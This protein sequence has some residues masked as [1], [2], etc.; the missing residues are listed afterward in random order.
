MLFIPLLTLAAT[1]G[2]AA[3]RRTPAPI[4]DTVTIAGD[5]TPL[6]LELRGRADRTPILLYLHG[7]PGNAAGLVLLRAY[8]GP[9]LEKEALVVYLHQ[10]GVLNSPAVPDTGLTVAHHVGD[11]RKTINYLTKR[12]P[13][14]PIVLLGHSWGGLLAVLTA[15]D[16]PKHIAGIVNASGPFDM[17]ATMRASYER[18]LAWARR[19]GNKEAIATLDSIG[20][21]PYQQIDQ[22]VAFSNRTSAADGGIGAHLDPQ[23]AFGRAP[24]TAPDESWTSVQLKI[25]AAMLRELY[26]IKTSDRIRTCRVPLLM[27]V[28][29][30]DAITPA[31]AIRPALAKWGGRKSLVE[32]P[33]SH[34]LPFVD[35]P[36]KF[37]DAVVGFVRTVA[38]P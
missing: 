34:H 37:V 6:F 3:L 17:E 22:Q 21:P 20:P 28:G 12:F 9:A 38:S 33:D 5:G 19:E 7:G 27:I 15:L 30:R 8:A 29:R 18:A 14:R 35:E 32:L 36:T 13:R 10:R 25:S 24:F 11:V 16:S 26:G 4:A 23:I 2:H 1:L 31:S